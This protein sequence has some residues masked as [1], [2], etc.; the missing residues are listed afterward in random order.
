MLLF[1]LVL[2]FETHLEKQL[3]WSDPAAWNFPVDRGLRERGNTVGSAMCPGANTARE[4]SGR[5]AGCRVR[6]GP[7][8]ALAA[9]QPCALMCTLLLRGVASGA[10]EQPSA[11]LGPQAHAG[12]A[13]S[14]ADAA[15]I[16]GWCPP[17]WA[18]SGQPIYPWPW[19]ACFTH[20]I[21]GGAGPIVAPNHRGSQV[22]PTVMSLHLVTRHRPQ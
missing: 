14:V 17:C 15:Q 19:C 8:P 13:E 5:A 21:P 7:G 6:A 20:V 11:W 1:S 22:K 16:S 18:R 3:M 2:L 9:H 4:H 10:T 12:K